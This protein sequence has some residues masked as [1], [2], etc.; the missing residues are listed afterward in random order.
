MSTFPGLTALAGHSASN[1]NRKPHNSEKK[2]IFFPCMT[3]RVSLINPPAAPSAATTAH[4]SHFSRPDFFVSFYILT[5][6]FALAPSHDFIG[7]FTTSY[8]ELARGQSQFN[9]YEVSAS[10][11]NTHFC[12]WAPDRVSA[13][14][15]TLTFLPQVT[16]PSQASLLHS[17]YGIFLSV[18]NSFFNFFFCVNSSKCKLHCMQKNLRSLALMASYDKPVV[19]PS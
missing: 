5:D 6:V 3:P 12:F 7:D 9:V 17:Y 18:W 19:A 4:S 8:R 10:H 1:Q 13:R 14:C 16:S 15:L 2:K 11:F